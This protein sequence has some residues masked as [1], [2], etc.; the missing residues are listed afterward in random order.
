MLVRG[1]GLLGD[2]DREITVVVVVDTGVDTG[3]GLI[4]NEPSVGRDCAI[5][6]VTVVG[7]LA[8]DPA[9]CGVLTTKEDRAGDADLRT[10][11]GSVFTTT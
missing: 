8:S 1:I 9:V 4:L 6:G 2:N 5:T 10:T 11:T 7:L 3:V